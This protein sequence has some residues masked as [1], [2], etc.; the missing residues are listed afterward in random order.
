MFTVR[1][2]NNNE[3][4]TLA[5]V[6]TIEEARDRGCKAYA[7]EEIEDTDIVQIWSD[8]DEHTAVEEFGSNE[9]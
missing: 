7:N 6:S 5:V 9:C 4:I 1:A 8:D 2:V 3:G